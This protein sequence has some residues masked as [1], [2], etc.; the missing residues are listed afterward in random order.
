MSN[1]W[2]H[3]NKIMD[4]IINKCRSYIENHSL[5]IWISRAN[6]L[7]SWNTEPIKPNFCPL[8]MILRQYKRHP[9]LLAFLG[10]YR[11]TPFSSDWKVSSKKTCLYASP[12]P[13]KVPAC[14]ED[15]HQL[16]RRCAPTKRL[17]TTLVAIWRLRPG[18]TFPRFSGYANSER[19]KEI[20]ELFEY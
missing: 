1:N 10:R 11:R 3:I 7:C 18:E 17:D 15:L 9:T 2:V 16:L 6:V 14:P 19:F 8:S 20:R 12:E 4:I 5:H 13:R